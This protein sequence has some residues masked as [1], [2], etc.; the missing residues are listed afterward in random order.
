M[1]RLSAVALGLVL[2][3]LDSLADRL[4]NFVVM[5]ADDLGAGEL[6]CY[7]HPGHRTPNL[8]KLAATGVQFLTCYATPLCHPTR[9]MIMTGQYGHHNG[10]Y[11]FGGRAGG[12]GPDDP[13]EQIVN[14]VTF[15]HMLKKAGYATGL[16]G[17]WQLSGGHPN[18]IREA[19]FDEYLMW[20]YKHNLPPGVEHTGAWEDKKG[21]K[22]ERYWHPSLVKNGEYVPTGPGDYG[23]DFFCNFAVDFI[24]RHKDKPFFLYCPMALTHA[25]HYTTPDTTKTLEDRHR[26]SKD[27]WRAN[28]EYADK[29]V[30]RIVAALEEAGLR[31]DTVLFF[32]GDNGTG[33]NGKG[34][35]TEL[36]CRVPG[37][38]NAPGRVKALGKTRALMDLSDVFPTLADYA[39]APLPGGVPIDGVSLRPVLEGEQDSVRDWAYGYLADRRVLRDSRWLLEDNSPHRKGRFFD[40]GSGRDGS[41]YRDVTDSAEAEVVAARKRFEEILA[42]KRVPEIADGSPLEKKGGKKKGAKAGDAGVGPAVAWDPAILQKPE[43]WNEGNGGAVVKAEGDGLRIG[44]PAGGKRVASWTAG[45]FLLPEGARE[46]RVKIASVSPGAQW[47]FKL[48]G[49]VGDGGQVFAAHTTE[50][51]KTGEVVIPLDPKVLDRPGE[52]WIVKLGV[53][54]GAGAS[55][56]FED[57]RF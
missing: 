57:I 12:P 5:M 56:V 39:G 17:K 54:G 11:N 4:P 50:D 6:G 33:G 35:A 30:G 45:R 19:G 14:H 8:D 44:V 52:A 29:I 15:G 55:A 38:W 2:P 37:I 24:R 16:S 20:A 42:D 13:A 3:C 36:G 7:G 23:P 10:I 47:M 43:L 28:V 34:Q 18:L 32:T 21:S 51:S 40:C 31:E 26:H 46:A 22:T 41:G 9:F 49:N 25:P 1:R 48:A 27:N 53:S